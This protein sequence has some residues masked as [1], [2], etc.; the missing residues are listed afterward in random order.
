MKYDLAFSWASTYGHAATL[1][2]QHAGR[3]VVIDL[4]C[5]AA[6][7]HQPMTELGFDYV[8][9]EFDEESIELCRSR[10]IRCE[11][12]DLRDIDAAV[13]RI[14]GVVG[15]DIVSVI[16]LLDVIE[17]LTD[18]DAIV[19]GLA[20]LTDRL[21]RPDQPAPLLLVSIPNVAHFDLGAKLAAGRWD[22]TPT[23]LLDNTHVTL[24]TEERVHDTLTRAGFVEAGRNDVVIA[25]TEQRFPDN[26]PAIAPLT[27]T[28]RY[29][30]ELRDH[31]DTAGSTYQFVRCYRLGSERRADAVA[32]FAEPFLSVVVATRGDEHDLTD[33]LTCLAAQTDRDI[34]VLVAVEGDDA[35]VVTVRSVIAEFAEDFVTSISVVPVSRTAAATVAALRS[36]RGRY[37]SVI[38]DDHLVTSNWVSEFRAGATDAGGRSVRA[39]ATV[40]DHTRVD[41][42]QRRVPVGGFQ[43]A[44][45]AEFDVLALL[46]RNHLPFGS[47]A[48]PRPAIGDLVSALAEVRS[49][50]DEAV[51]AATEWTAA[52]RLALRTGV[53][54]RPAVTSV[55]RRL[56]GSRLP[57]SEAVTRQLVAQLDESP[58]L[59]PPGS[60]GRIVALLRDAEIRD[61]SYASAVARVEALERSRYWRATA[62]LRWLSARRGAF[63]RGG[64][65]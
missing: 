42:A 59:L 52:I 33:L 14:V 22:V 1:A 60:V 55:R 39:R 54:D 48:A 21:T 43:P 12:I 58:L 6:A 26:H 28:F 41:R 45:L 46:Q 65:R 31:A 47:F 3:G 36:A 27:P 16:S 20:M 40:Q 49:D 2:A 62:P 56:L 17:H 10:G 13:D 63:R 44:T 15:D 37:V 50:G 29:L 64:D 4:G 34:E 51:A 61:R 35:A 8:G 18:P 53:V 25:E 32:E 7:F 30:R 11:P 19:G 9:F 38:T 23:G 5:G 57:E 24:F